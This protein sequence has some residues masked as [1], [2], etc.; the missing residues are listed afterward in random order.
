MNVNSDTYTSTFIILLIF[1]ILKFAA[2]FNHAGIMLQYVVKYVHVLPKKKKKP[3]SYI[4]IYLYVD[5]LYIRKLITAGTCIKGVRYKLN[6]KSIYKD[7]LAESVPH[8]KGCCF[9][10]LTSIMH[11]FQINFIFSDQLSDILNK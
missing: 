4:Y 3:Y 10:F 1:Y 9:L 8:K 11:H 7:C 6:G 5:I 2:F